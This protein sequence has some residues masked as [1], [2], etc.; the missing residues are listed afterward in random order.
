PRASSCCPALA[1]GEPRGR[2]HATTTEAR[3]SR[4]A[5]GPSGQRPM[6][7]RR[8]Q[9]VH[10]TLGGRSAHGRACGVLILLASCVAL[11]CSSGSTAR[12]ATGGGGG[13]GGSSGG[14]GIGAGGDNGQAGSNA[15]GT[16]GGLGGADAGDEG[17]RAD[18]R[19]DIVVV[20]ADD[21]GF[22]DVGSFGGE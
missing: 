6:T 2:A 13:G 3:N 22:S 14:R 11:D 21:M 9:G 18:G 19:P 15:G 8:A 12:G 16:A 4:Q 17:T 7:S 5:D 10:M 1:K 20:V